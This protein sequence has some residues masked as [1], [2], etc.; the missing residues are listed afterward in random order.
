MS[1]CT[2][3]FKCFMFAYRDG[4]AYEFQLF[5]CYESVEKIG[6][7]DVTSKTCFQYVL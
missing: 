6:V 7:A 5:K 3:G 4:V 1:S 2:F